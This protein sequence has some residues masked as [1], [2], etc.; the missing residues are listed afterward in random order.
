MNLEDYLKNADDIYNEIVKFH[1][2]MKQDDIDNK[3]LEIQSGI[4][5]IQAVAKK[6]AD[7]SNSIKRINNRKKIMLNGTDSYKFIDP[8][9]NIETHG[10]IR[11]HLMKK[12]N[13]NP[14]IKIPVVI[15]QKEEFIP[16]SFIYYIEETQQFAV[17][18]NG[19]NIKGNLGNILEYG[20]EKTSLCEYRSECKT[21][22]KCKYYHPPEDYIKLNIPIVH[23]IRNFTVGSWIYSK[24]NNIKYNRHIGNGASLHSD[25]EN[26][27]K[28]SYIEEIETRKSQ[29]IHDILVYITIQQKNMDNEKSWN[30]YNYL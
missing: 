8:Y 14:D 7:I 20:N 27:K 4:K 12:I 29:M 23:Q 16:T 9:P 28:D 13:I 6:M 10:V 21:I 19:F 25:I 22:N 5:I 26:L 30:F 15:V 2:I 17:N 18:I 1:I 3:I 24:K 11:N